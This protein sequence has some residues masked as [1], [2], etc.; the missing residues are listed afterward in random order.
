MPRRRRESRAIS[1]PTATSAANP[2]LAAVAELRNRFLEAMDDDFNTGGGIGTLFDLVRA[3]NKYADDEK[4]EEP[5][6][7]HARAARRAPPRASRC[8]AS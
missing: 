2:L 1:Q 3:I 7:P 4:L 5:A 6:Q 8:F